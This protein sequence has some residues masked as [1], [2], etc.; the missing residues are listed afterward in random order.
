L[1]EET[2]EALDRIAAGTFGT[3]ADC[4]RE[5]A[6]LRLEAVPYTRWCIRCAARHERSEGPRLEASERPH[7]GPRLPR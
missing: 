3:C 6:A 4:G 1:L 2:V 7:G 5:I